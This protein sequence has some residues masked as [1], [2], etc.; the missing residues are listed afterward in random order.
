VTPQL[1]FATTTTIIILII[2]INKIQEIGS[3]AV[4]VLRYSFGIIDWH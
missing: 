4:P 1:Q 3:L 2:I